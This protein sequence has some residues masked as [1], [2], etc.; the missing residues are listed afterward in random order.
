MQIYKKYPTCSQIQLLKDF[1]DCPPKP[2]T[3]RALKYSFDI[4]YLSGIGDKYYS[5][6]RLFRVFKD[7]SSK[8]RDQNL[9]AMLEIVKNAKKGIKAPIQDFFSTFKNLKLVQKIGTLFLL[10][11]IS[12]FFLL[13][14]FF[15]LGKTAIHL[16]R[17]P[18][19]GKDA[20]GFFS[21]I[22]QQKSEIVVKPKS[23]KKAQISLDAVISHEHIHLLQHRIFPNR[24]VDLLGYEFKEN[25]R[26]FLNQ[27]ALKS[28][29]TF[30]H[31]S[32]N[33]VEARL[34][35]VVL[36]YY[37][38]YGNLPI[39]YQGFL[40]MILSCDVLGEPV[41]RILSKYDVAVPEY[42]GRKYS[43]RDVSPAEDIAIML[44]YFPDFS[45]AKR[46]V[47]EALSMMYGNL[48]V[49]YGDSDLAFK[50]LETV[51]CSDFYTQLYGEK[52]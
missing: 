46:F 33:E 38:A 24:Q 48:L 2:L 51:E 41:S 40:V 49:L 17:M 8:I 45:Y 9:K 47:C 52:T 34:H 6:S 42:D 29:K 37:R 5:L 3:T 26:K 32:L 30:Y 44:G 12:P 18:V 35:E 19:T 15:V 11:F 22:T 25:I 21:P 16:Y 4:I 7:D 39:D 13:F 20:L 14:I 31:L 50:Y 36:S 27:P 23:I 1:G 43:L 28:E 10:F